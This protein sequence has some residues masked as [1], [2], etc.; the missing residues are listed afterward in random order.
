MI[1][2]HHERIYIYPT[3]TPQFS[4]TGDEPNSLRKC[5]F[6]AKTKSYKMQ[7]R[8]GLGGTE[9]VRSGVPSEKTPP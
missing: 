7:A 5:A 6:G 2:Q 8:G 9:V 1:K 3:V 4:T